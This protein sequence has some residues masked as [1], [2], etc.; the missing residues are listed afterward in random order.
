[1]LLLLGCLLAQGAARACEDIHLDIIVVPIFST[2]HTSRNRT[3]TL[4]AVREE[5]LEDSALLP[6][7]DQSV[8]L[9]RVLDG[10]EEGA[11]AI[12]PQV[13]LYERI[14]A[15][16]GA[17]HGT[18]GRSTLLIGVQSGTVALLRTSTLGRP[19]IAA[20]FVMLLTDAAAG[21]AIVTGLVVDVAVV[22]AVDCVST[23][24][25]CVLWCVCR[26][27]RFVGVYKQDE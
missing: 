6:A 3:T 7:A 4:T 1:L 26:R 18:P 5:R 10:P 25:S 21:L 15:R 12:G 2:S 17:E 20:L 8:L 19:E 22:T 14:E 23:T 11:A 13:A 27:V 24:S 9:R 16:N